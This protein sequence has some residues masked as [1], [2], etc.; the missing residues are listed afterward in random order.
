MPILL[1][2]AAARPRFVPARI[3]LGQYVLIQPGGRYGPRVDAFGTLRATL[4]VVCLRL[5]SLRFGRFARPSGTYL[6]FAPIV[7]LP[8][9]HSG[10]LRFRCTS[11]RSGCRDASSRRL[12]TNGYEK[13]GLVLTPD[14][15]MDEHLSSE[16]GLSGTAS[17]IVPLLLNGMAA[18]R[19]E[20]ES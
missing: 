11:I 14:T 5:T 10:Y 18:G 9:F 17:H 16:R 13:C 3:S 2:L 12:A 8:L 1:R 15:V 7:H 19:S 20:R 4:R 6:R